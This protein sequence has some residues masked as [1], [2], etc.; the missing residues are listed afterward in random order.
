M[1]TVAFTIMQ[2]FTLIVGVVVAPTHEQFGMCGG[3]GNCVFMFAIV[4]FLVSSVRS[5]LAC[6][7]SCGRHYCI[8]VSFFLSE[9]VHLMVGKSIFETRAGL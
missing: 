4:G 8:C 9:M 1:S 7:M 6:V 2:V 3:A 5:K